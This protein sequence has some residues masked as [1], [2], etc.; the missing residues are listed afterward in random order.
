[1]ADKIL[2]VVICKWKHFETDECFIEHMENKSVDKSFI[3]ADV[4][5]HLE[6]LTFKS[7]PQTFHRHLRVNFVLWK[8]S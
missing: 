4:K 2:H 5:V 8:Q 1:M 3:N 6:L 7:I